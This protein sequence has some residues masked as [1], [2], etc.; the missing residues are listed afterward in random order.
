MGRQ[1]A[2]AFFCVV[3]PCYY[4][5]HAYIPHISYHTVLAK[6]YLAEQTYQI[7]QTKY[8]RHNFLCMCLFICFLTLLTFALRITVSS[9][10]SLLII[11][12]IA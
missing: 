6:I 7:Y 10:W 11:H 5:T 12:L 9:W 4:W 1:D 3:I 8:C 2:N